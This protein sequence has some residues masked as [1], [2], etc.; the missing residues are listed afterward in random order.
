MGFTMSDARNRVV[1]VSGPA[2]GIGKSFVCS[3]FSVLLA[4]TGSAASRVLLVDGD[5]RR[6]N[7]HH[8]FGIDHRSG[9]LSE[10][11]SGQ[12]PWLQAVRATEVPGLDIITSGTLPPNPSELL[13]SSRFSEFIQEISQAYD[14][15]IIDAPPVL[16]VTDAV[17]IGRQ[18]GTTLLIVKA[19]THTLDEIHA[20]IKRFESAGIKPKG[21]IFNDVQLVNVGYRYYR[22]AY[23]YGYKK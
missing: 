2:P 12:K 14:I 6:G 8:Y 20:C 11:L 10:I 15:V 5:M 21:C 22:Y 18:A 4:Q 17:I 3:N 16:A 9:G 23:H 19:K 1:M 7:L 13:M